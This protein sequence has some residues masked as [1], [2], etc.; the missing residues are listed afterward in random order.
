MIRFVSSLF[1]PSYAP[2]GIDLGST[3]LKLAQ[4]AAG[5]DGRVE[6]VCFASAD[7]PPELANDALGRIDFFEQTVPKLLSRGRFRGRRAV[8][9]LPVA[10]MHFGRVRV[11]PMDEAAIKEAIL[12][13]ASADLP[14]HPT[15]ATIRHLVVGEVYEDN[16][17]CHEVIIMATRRELTERL[18]A[19]TARSGLYVKAMCAEPPAIAAGIDQ[20]LQLL[21][22]PA[23]VAGTARVIVDIGGMGTRIYVAVGPRIQFARSISL[24]GD[25]FPAAI[26][27]QLRIDAAQAKK[28]WMALANHSTSAE[29]SRNSSLQR[30]GQSDSNHAPSMRDQPNRSQQNRATDTDQLLAAERACEPLR[31]RMVN[32][33]ELCCRYH[34]STFPAIA[35]GQVIFLGCAAAQ[36]RLCQR[37]AAELGLP[38]MISNPLEH[39]ASAESLEPMQSEKPACAWT[40]AVGLG[41]TVLTT[42]QNA[43]QAA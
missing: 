22:Q 26:A 43:Q 25:H 30:S 23:S 10:N 2:I 21:A 14:Y 11:P 24:G 40:V 7:V 33:I 35:L 41:L 38:L 8:L 15:R 20:E 3:S 17:P 9:G 39:L 12:F 5:A 32:E 6:L 36:S 19:A 37:I 31:L 27:K 42:S 4:I 16:Q 1:K 29:G 28:L 18:L 34:T 13:E